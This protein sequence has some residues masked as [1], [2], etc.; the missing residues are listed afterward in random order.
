MFRMRLITAIILVVMVIAQ[1]N[2]ID[3]S[4]NKQVQLKG[5]F[6][7]LVHSG[8]EDFY[9]TF[10]RSRLTISNKVFLSMLKLFAKKGQKEVNFLEIW[11][12]DLLKRLRQ[13]E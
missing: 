4:E 10:G 8:I 11:L 2:A 7:L 3:L 13:R 5:S 1:K 12:D 9:M 6:C